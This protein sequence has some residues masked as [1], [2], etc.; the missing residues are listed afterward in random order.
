MIGACKGV[1]KA[2]AIVVAIFFLT[3]MVLHTTAYARAGGGRSSGGGMRSSG[4]YRGATSAP[5][6]SPAQQSEPGASDRSPMSGPNSPGK[7]FLYGLGGGLFGG[8]IGNMLFGGGGYNQGWGGGGFGFGD[9]IVILIIVGIVYS[10]VKRY[11]AR[12][13]IEVGGADAGVYASSAY[14]SPSYGPSTYTPEGHQDII[15][16]GLRHISQMDPAFNENAFKEVASDIFFKIQGAWTK[17][18]LRGV[19]HL[20]SPQ[21]LDTFQMDLNNFIS[22]KEFNR[23]ENI[24]VR[25]VDI[26]DAV[27]DQGE[28]YITIKFLASLLDYN[29]DE[30]TGNVIAGSPTDPVKF[31]EYWTFTR[32]VGGE[33]WALA[34]ITQEQDYH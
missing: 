33:N 14:D 15:A 12:K 34:A 16:T 32:K 21:M 5:Y 27:Q 10:L 17:R 24:A 22:N 2:L 1:L 9:F 7:S 25:Q 11:R 6:Q 29:V 3:V 19:S 8:M 13:A 20:L 28:E 30:T 4:S 18:D 31:L 26:V 23:L